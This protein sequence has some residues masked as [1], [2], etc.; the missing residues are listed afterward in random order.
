M[1]TFALL[2]VLLMASPALS[3]TVSSS[4]LDP[5]AA[6]EI[7]RK[8]SVE[9]G[10]HGTIRALK[11]RL[12]RELVDLGLRATVHRMPHFS[13]G[14]ARI[15]GIADDAKIDTARVDRPVTCRWEVDPL[16]LSI[17]LDLVHRYGLVTSVEVD[18]DDRR[19]AL[20]VKGHHHVNYGLS[21]ED[22]GNTL[23]ALVTLPF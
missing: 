19:I 17:T 14:V 7:Q 3:Q 5:G 1:K 23:Q 11:H 15:L 9:E 4:S 22:E 21:Y 20:G 18:L 16:D 10:G 8:G 6:I 2:L 13:A 12:R